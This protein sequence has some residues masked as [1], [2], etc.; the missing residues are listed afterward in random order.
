[1]KFFT[2]KSKGFGIIETLVACAILILIC[3]ALLSINVIITR[4]IAFARSRA[5]AYNLAQEAIESG[6][7]IRDSNLIDG[8]AT[9]N[10]DSFV[11]NTANS[12]FS[13]PTT[14][15][16]NFYNIS[17][18]LPNCYGTPRIYLIPSANEEPIKIGGITYTRKI[19]FLDSGVD[20][21]VVST[22]VTNENAIRMVAEVSW[23]Q[24]GSGRSVE[25][26]EL[27]TNWK[28]GF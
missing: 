10:W 20:P 8:V 14:S 18:A 22:D 19:H 25:V 5:I 2:G 24:N 21:V 16:N 4:N 17:F 7:Q 3:G 6:R 13:R 27:L 1:M 9:S 26:S 12:S 28:R 11:C 23:N 15:K